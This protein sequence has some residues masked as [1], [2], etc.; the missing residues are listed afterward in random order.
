M[1]RVI[2]F[3]PKTDNFSRKLARKKVKELVTIVA[4]EARYTTL[5][6]TGNSYPTPTG[7]LSRSIRSNVGTKGRWRVV[8]SVGSNLSIAEVVH[9]GARPHWI[10]PRNVPGMKF[11]WKAKGRLVCIKTPVYHPGMN[12]KFYL[13]EPLKIEGRRLGWRVVTSAVTERL[14][15]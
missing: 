11:Y 7:R 15:R 10:R 3:Q 8:G 13:V 4:R 12:G 5:R 9:D 1:A 6:Y 2:I 14:V